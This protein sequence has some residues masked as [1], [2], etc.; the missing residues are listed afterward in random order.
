M[1]TPL[2]EAPPVPVETEFLGEWFTERFSPYESHSHR[3]KRKIVQTKTAFQNAVLVDSNAFGRCLILDGEMQS[4]QS[5]EFIYHECLVH[6][7]LVTHPEPKNILILGGGEGATI[8]EI[9]RHPSVRR[10]T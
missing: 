2:S 10:V 9:L 7:A 4:A 5:D 3:L 6:P 1:D 8:R